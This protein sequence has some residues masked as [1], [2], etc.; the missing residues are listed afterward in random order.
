MTNRSQ[1]DVD[2][3]TAV[4]SIAADVGGIN[5]DS[6]IMDEANPGH[7]VFSVEREK[8]LQ[9]DVCREL[10]EANVM[11]KKIGKE[12][13][14]AR[15]KE[16]KVEADKLLDASEVKRRLLQG[17][18]SLQSLQAKRNNE[19]QMQASGMGV[20]QD[21]AQENE[22]KKL[23]AAGKIFNAMFSQNPQADTEIEEGLERMLVS[24]KFIKESMTGLNKE[25]SRVKTARQMI[26]ITTA[27]GLVLVPTLVANK[28]ADSIQQK[29]PYW[30]VIDHW[31]GRGHINLALFN[32]KGTANLRAAAGNAASANVD[33][34]IPDNTRN[35]SNFATGTVP[36]NY[37]LVENS[38]NPEM[39]LMR[40]SELVAA[41]YAEGLAEQVAIGAGSSGAIQGIITGGDIGVDLA[42]SF[43]FDKLVEHQDM[44]APAYRN[45]MS[46]AWTMHHNIFSS[47]RQLKDSD[48]RP[49]FLQ[50]LQ[51]T[52]RSFYMPT[53]LGAKV[54][55]NAYADGTVSDGDRIAAFGDFKQY[56]LQQAYRMPLIRRLEESSNATNNAGGSFGIAARN[57][58]AAGVQNPD[59]IQVLQ[60]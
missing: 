22:L 35:A 37:D 58:V 5:T 47:I 19:L 50:G 26:E 43:T 56:C 59:A 24:D 10:T 11:V 32:T 25:L 39:F 54:C 17:N 3:E 60:Y 2:Y 46:C 31:E 51:D 33:V 23:K 1:A 42:G 20:S 7:G 21:E 14:L 53:F 28:I 44:L 36:V 49:I 15:A 9:E 57:S 55:L 40:L 38:N 16:L 34:P 27:K 12:K 41:L 13:D 6:Q 4:A 29:F 18:Q 48:N 45:S 52:E 30:D 8:Q